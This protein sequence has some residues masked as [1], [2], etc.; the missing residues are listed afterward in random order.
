HTATLG[1]HQS[2]W[3]NQPRLERGIAYQLSKDRLSPEQAKW[4]QNHPG[5]WLLRELG[6][7]LW[8]FVCVIGKVASFIPGLVMRIDVKGAFVKFWKFISSQRYRTSIAKGYVGKRIH[9]WIKRKQLSRKEA[10]ILQQE[11]KHAS[12]STSYISDLGAHLGMKGA[13][14]FLELTLLAALIATGLV[15]WF[16]AGAILALDGVLFRSSYT[17]YRMVHAAAKRK[18]L[19]WVALFVG[20]L[21]GLG[22]S[23]FAVQMLYAANERHHNIARFIVIDT[24]T[25]I[26]CWLPIWGG[27]DTLTEHWFNRLGTRIAR[28]R[29]VAADSEHQTQTA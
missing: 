10:A 26:G 6:R 29:I 22:S 20:L 2:R 19:P 1:F 28:R 11:L 17:G 15:S 8:K 18:P 24:F 23:A 25:R 4:F 13:F 9:H 7:S 27:K 14:I 21:P 16:F 12:E 5:T 3:K